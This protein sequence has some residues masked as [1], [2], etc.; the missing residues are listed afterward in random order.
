MRRAS[1]AQ[2]LT[3][4]RLDNLHIADLPQEVLCQ[5]TAL[6]SLYLQHNDLASMA[7]VACLKQL[8]FLTVAHNSL[9][10]VSK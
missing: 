8:S 9:T 3:H 5:L 6:R 10:E 1:A 7:A 4:V 2:Q